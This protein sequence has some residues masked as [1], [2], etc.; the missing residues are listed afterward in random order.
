MKHF[1]LLLILLTTTYTQAQ[2]IRYVKVGSTGNGTSWSNASGDLQ[3]MINQSNNGDKI[4]VAEG[5]YI[6]TTKASNEI[7]E[8]LT[9]ES[10]GITND[11]AK[12]FVLKEGVEI[13][14]GFAANSPTTNLN[15]RNFVA[16]ETIISTDI[17]QDDAG[18]T[19]LST[20]TENYYHAVIAAGISTNSRLDGFTIKGGTWS[21]PNDYDYI[22]INN[23][24]VQQGFGGGITIVDAKVT[25]ENIKIHNT[26]RPIYSKNSNVNIKNL[27]IT[28]SFGSFEINNATFAIE[29][30]TFTD[31]NGNLS[32][33][34]SENLPNSIIKIKNA[35]FARNLAG[36][37]AILINRTATTN[38]TVNLDRV[39]F[40]GNKSS[41]YGTIQNN[42]CDLT[43]SNSVATGNFSTNQTGFL[44]V[45]TLNPAIITKV[46]IINCTIVGNKNS[47]DWGNNSGALSGVDI[48]N[49][50]VRIRNSIIYGNKMGENFVNI[51]LNNSNPNFTIANSIVEGIYNTDGTWKTNM[52]VNMGGNL[53]SIPNFVSS[54]EMVNTA[55]DTGNF[56]LTSGSSGIDAGND[57]F[58]SS[59]IDP[60]H[61]LDAANE[62]R[63]MGSAI[64]IGAYEFIDVLGVK[65]S[66]NLDLK[67]Y[68][69]PTSEYVAIYGL[70]NEGTFQIFNLNGKAITSISPISNGQEVS[71]SKLTTGVYLIKIATSDG[72]HSQK[73]IKK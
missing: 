44:V 37:S 15:S 63:F 49:A 22:L 43:I 51:P 10:K 13:Y 3:M 45:N 33:S 26:G 18:Y 62:A 16:N 12:A 53:N 24:K 35:L 42:G 69:N 32:L 58:Y 34:A 57:L 2:T 52:G 71:L 8:W 70:K 65:N 48:T 19:N 39:H 23:S 59:I 11:K 21:A 6:P 31:N 60:N 30:L 4:Y 28:N 61:V 64:D 67:I 1:Y 27:A 25:F 41:S 17:N 50:H 29:N 20:Y 7:F 73:I 68:P 56:K 38:V 55:F 5:T 46:D 9:N 54:V 14:G 40:K 72:N 66:K 36:P 47:F